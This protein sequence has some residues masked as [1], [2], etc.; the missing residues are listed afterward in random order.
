MQATIGSNLSRASEL[1]REGHLVAFPTETVY[2]LGA[3]ALNPEAVARIFEAKGRPHFDPLIVHVPDL[4]GLEPL[5]SEVPQIARELATKFWPGPLTMVLP[6]TSLVPDLVTSGLPTV[7]VRLPKH[8]LAQE[9]LKQAGVPIAAPSA[10]RFG[11]LS[12]TRAEHVLEQLGH[13]VDYILD[14]GP[15]EVGVESTVVDVTCQPPRL[16][17]PGGVTWEDLQEIVGHIEI[18]DTAEEGETPAAPGMLTKH[19]A[20]ETRVVI[21]DGLDELQLPRTECCLLSLGPI[22]GTDGFQAV[23]ILSQNRDLREAATHFFAAMRRLDVLKS[24]QIIAIRF[25]NEGLG[26]A[27]ND[28]LQRAAQSAE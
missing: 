4:S 19:Y 20:P 5:T 28:R 21:L 27:L 7:A 3:N 11:R 12:P 22:S 9:L 16:L 8:P 14:G 18:Q 24:R 10:N 1:I 15:C 6:K 23:E 25:P 2:G 26:R 13:R 17:R